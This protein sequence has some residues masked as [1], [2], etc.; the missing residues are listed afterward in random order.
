MRCALLAAICALGAP[1]A[2]A[3]KGRSLV[4]VGSPHSIGD[5]TDLSAGDL[6]AEEIE[7]FAGDEDARERADCVAARHDNQKTAAQLFR[8]ERMSA[9]Q[10]TA[11]ARLKQKVRELRALTAA[12]PGF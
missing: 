10:D 7:D 9:E 5:L 12:A 6:L 11:I 8:L 1:T 2:G 4:T 3:A